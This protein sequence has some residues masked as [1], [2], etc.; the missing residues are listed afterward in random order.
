MNR[1]FSKCKTKEDVEKVFKKNESKFRIII[2][3]KNWK[4]RGKDRR[5]EAGK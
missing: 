2:R 5:K 4:V 3:L 1:D